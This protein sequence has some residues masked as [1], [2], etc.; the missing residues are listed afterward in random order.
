MRWLSWC[1]LLALTAGQ[2]NEN[3][4]VLRGKVTRAGTAEA[5]SEVQIVL[6]G[7]LVGPAANAAV[8]NP[9]A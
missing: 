9:S 7:P 8:S 2:A 1:M 4:G 6:V 5:I 3:Q